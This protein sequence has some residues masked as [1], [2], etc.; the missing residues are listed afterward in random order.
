MRDVVQRYGLP[1]TSFILIA[2]SFWVLLLI[3][4][5]ELMMVDASFRP[6]LLPEEVGGPKDVYTLA[7]Y[8]TLWTNTIHLSIFFKTIWGSA[9]VT[10]LTLIV[11]YPVAYF[12][13]QVAKGQE[14]S[15]TMLL[16]VIPFWINEILRTFAWF[17]ILAYQ[18]PLNAA[19]LWLGVLDQPVR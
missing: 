14:A 13:G 9:L 1:L 16:L 12:L 7:N 8:G 17:I 18:G 5:P 2:C 3:V 6:S 19:L 4:L 10:I 11:C 15:T